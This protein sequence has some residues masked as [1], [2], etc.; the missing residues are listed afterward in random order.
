MLYINTLESA[1]RICE[2]LSSQTRINIIKL[3]QQTGSMNMDM[4]AK[5]LGITNGALTAHIK[6]L[7]ECGIVNVR[8]CSIE[9]GTQKL[10][11]LGESKLVIDFIDKTITG[12][13]ER[14]ELNVG[15]YSS[16]K[17][18]P[19][20][21][22]CDRNHALFEFD[23]PH[24]FKYPERFNAEMIWFC[25]G[26]VCYSFPNPLTEDKTLTE[27]QIS[28]ELSA[29]GPFL[30]RNYP[31][32]IDFYNHGHLLGSHVSPGE[33]DEHKGNL[34]PDWWFY[35]QYGEQITISIG[36]NG[37]CINGLEASEYSIRDVVADAKEEAF[38]DLKISC[39]NHTST[40]GGIMLFGKGFGD[41]PQGIVMKVFY[42]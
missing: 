8:L 20:C 11:S 21:G 13:Y 34:T 32:A 14:L 3:L 18:S 38:V 15:Q 17:I 37:T 24:F 19:T 39:E 5:A 25:D 6:K 26:F 16:S 27:I 1:R 10:C 23:M 36:E 2:V 4:M 9:H 30:A 35:G 33:F 40:K 12:K 22:L 31:A 42:Q 41:L 7:S 28:M 29:E